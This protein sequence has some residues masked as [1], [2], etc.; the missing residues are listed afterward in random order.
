MAYLKERT[1]QTCAGRERM[2]PPLRIRMFG[3]FHVWR[4]GEV[5]DSLQELRAHRMAT[6]LLALLALYPNR[7]LDKSEATTLLWGGG[8]S[9]DNLN[10]AI[11]ALCRA[12]GPDSGR[13][14]SV[15]RAV[16]LD[17]SGVDV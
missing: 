13:V 8:Y 2:D 7:P 10:K 15:S 5:E 12:L 11:Q 9:E 17:L 1:G 16:R 3:P 14:S 4:D 6:R